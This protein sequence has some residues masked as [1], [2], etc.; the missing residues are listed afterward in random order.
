MRYENT[1]PLRA[2]PV[3]TVQVHDSHSIKNLPA[4]AFFASAAAFF[5][6]ADTDLA[7]GYIS[8]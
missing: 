4:S 8:I 7:E 6:S 5:S 2:H 3:C 1:D